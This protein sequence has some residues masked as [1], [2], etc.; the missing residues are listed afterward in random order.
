MKPRWILLAIL[1]G[2]SL[3]R[4]YG[5]D[6]DSVWDDEA[7]T[8]LACAADTAQGVLNLI[9]VFIPANPPLD[10]LVRHFAMQLAGA[11]TFVFRLPSV[12]FSVIGIFCVFLLAR[13]LFGP[14]VA[15]ITAVLLAIH[16]IDIYYAHEGRNY[17]ILNIVVPLATLALI[18]ALYAN[19]LRSWCWYTLALAACFYAHL[20]T[21][22]VALTHGLVLTAMVAA[23]G[24]R[25]ELDRFVGRLL[26]NYLV[27]SLAAGLL[28]VPW[29]L[30]FLRTTGTPVLL[31]SAGTNYAPLPYLVSSFG[32][33]IGIRSPFYCL[34]VLG[35]LAIALRRQG[36]AGIVPLTIAVCGIT[37]YVLT[38]SSFFHLRYVFF[39]I[40]F[41]LMLVA[42]GIDWL[43]VAVH[44]WLVK[45]APRLG[46]WTQRLQPSHFALVIVLGVAFFDAEYVKR[47]YESRKVI[48]ND[49]RGASQLVG[50]NWS[51]DD[52]IVV[53]ER[54]VA[55]FAVYCKAHVYSLHQQSHLGSLEN[56]S[57]SHG[58]LAQW[59]TLSV[60][61]TRPDTSADLYNYLR[62]RH[63]SRM[64]VVL[65][66][67]LDGI[68]ALEAFEKTG[69]RL[70][71]WHFKGITV[72]LCSLK[73]SPTKIGTVSGRSALD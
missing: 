66:E 16:G 52:A 70:E 48:D 22:G 55:N 34:P 40:P 10:P 38:R 15:L 61:G 9:P 67:G 54:L 68:S 11:S 29:L 21:V 2:A 30:A 39:T 27:S 45:L 41:F 4:L 59:S 13:R 37:S 23:H 14:R 73:G 25:G 35:L 12:V 46:S 43:A 56:I 71:Q 8:Y 50:S 7:R 44:Q 69:G 72:L 26:L 49:W 17:A 1:G 6:Q 32:F 53:P 36:R 5:L 33:G 62:A 20:L 51:A 60:D 57:A 24:W 18:Q 65:P 64:W 42:C 47:Y 3:L 63:H 58:L 28:F 31:T 19:D